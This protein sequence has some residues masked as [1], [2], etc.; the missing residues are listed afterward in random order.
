MDGFHLGPSAPAHRRVVGGDHTSAAIAAASVIAKTARDRLMAGPM[1]EAYPEW[2]FADHVGYATPEHHSALRAGGLSPLHRRSFQSMA[3]PHI[4]AELEALAAHG[5]PTA[6]G[7][8]PHARPDPSEAHGEDVEPRLEPREVRPARHERLR[9]P[10]DPRPL[11]RRD[12][13]DEGRGI[14]ARLHLAQR[15][16]AAARGDEIDLAA[17]AAPSRRQDGPAAAAQMPRRRPLASPSAL[18]PD[19][20]AASPSR[21]PVTGLHA[22]VTDGA[23]GCAG[24]RQSPQRNPVGAAATGSGVPGRP[25]GS[26]GS[27]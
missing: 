27:L 5:P 16:D 21:R 10:A 6:A 26:D 2:G 14:G 12:R 3:Y 24:G 7:L 11:R 23:R 8:M 15:E 25:S 22:G 19:R 18:A 4:I 9:R 1:A 20:H 17:G 13:L